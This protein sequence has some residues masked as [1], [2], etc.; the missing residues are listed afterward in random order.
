MGTAFYAYCKHANLGYWKDAA[1]DDILWNLLLD[2]SVNFCR[3]KKSKKNSIFSRAFLTAN[4]SGAGTVLL[5]SLHALGTMVAGT[6]VGVLMRKL[7]YR[8]AWNVDVWLQY[9]PMSLAD[10]SFD[11]DG[12]C[13]ALRMCMGESKPVSL[14]GSEEFTEV[15]GGEGITG[16]TDGSCGRARSLKNVAVSSFQRPLTSIAKKTKRHRNVFAIG[17]QA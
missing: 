5:G 6:V 13:V 16:L 7:L 2:S 14:G 12:N 8:G 10:R 1:F 3:I 17:V 11:S 4:C 9:F 15:G